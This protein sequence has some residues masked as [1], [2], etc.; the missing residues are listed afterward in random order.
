MLPTLH[1]VGLPHTETTADYL[2]CAYTQKLVKFCRMMHGRG[3]KIILYGG[4]RN[5]APCDEFVS[6]VSNEDR[7]GWFG[8]WNPLNPFTN[9]TWNPTEPPFWTM[10]ERAIKAIQERA[11][12]QDLIL[13]IAGTAQMP[14][15]AAFPNM[16]SVEWGVGYE[17]IFSNFC[18]FESYAWMHYLYGKRGIQDGRYYDQVIPNF[19]D[20]S[21]FT[22]L[23]AWEKKEDYLLFIGRLTARKGPHV[24]SQ[25]AEACGRRLV[26]AGPG[27]NS[28][29]TRADGTVVIEADHVTLE[30][31]HLD[32][33]GPVNVH[34]RSDLMAYAA[35]VI[36]PTLY[37]EPFGGVAVEAMLSGTPVVASDWG[38]FS[39]TVE[40]G[41]SGYRFRTLKQ[42]VSAVDS[43]GLL[44]P[45]EIRLWA[46]D[47]Y[48]LDA[49][50]PRFETWF[51]QLDGLWGE[52]WT[53]KPPMCN[54]YIR[55]G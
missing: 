55:V 33:V 52:G 34:Q 7:V 12:P 43:C 40:E 30:G 18:A 13:L 49:V 46:M 32:Y 44:D 28:V 45:A 27:A 21:E 17:G 24:A 15:A 35:A 53:E 51:T 36:V 11:Q 54:R 16:L 10:N 39:E 48:S 19:F 5:E 38:A 42:G 23:R 3:R 8:E 14:I 4:A 9:L 6:L 47:R 25:I 31:K 2:I 37:L 41:V 20:P 29:T 1:L 22:P 26:V 50:A